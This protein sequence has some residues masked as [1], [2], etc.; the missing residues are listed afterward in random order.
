M[1]RSCQT[2]HGEAWGSLT[3]ERLLEMGEIVHE[4]IGKG[5]GMQYEKLTHGFW[6]GYIRRET[7]LAG[8]TVKPSANCFLMCITVR[9]S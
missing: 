7:L 8:G 4:A 1:L 3:C 6:R 5:E 9:S 2:G